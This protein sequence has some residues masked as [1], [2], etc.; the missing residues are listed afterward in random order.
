MTERVSF[1]TPNHRVN[2]VFVGK[3]SEVDH[4][5]AKCIEAG[6][7][8]ILLFPLFRHGAHGRGFEKCSKD[9][10]VC[11]IVRFCAA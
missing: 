3:G 9:V 5:L 6:Q 8:S 11:D 10:V 7:F 4:V 2:L 1:V